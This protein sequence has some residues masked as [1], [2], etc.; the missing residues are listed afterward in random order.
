MKGLL[1]KDFCILK[2][3]MKIVAVLV[4]FYAIWAIVS[5]TPSMMGVM[6]ILL[7]IMLPI[8]SMSYDE[9]GQWYRYA[10][11]LPISRRAL[12]L[13]KYVLGFL[14]A[15]GGLVVSAIGN[16]VVLFLTNWENS[17][18]S[19]LII[20]GFLEIGMIFLSIIIPVL[21]QFGVEKGR[22]LVVVIAV[23]PSL[24]IAMLGSLLKTS[25]VPMPSG[26]VL[27]AIFY[28]SPL[29]T[30]AVFLVSFRISVGI[31]RKKEY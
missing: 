25:G 17:L 5:K 18:E 24:L 16:L 14:V 21:F 23:V 12:V 9:A 15:L 2:K 7:S 19:W 26:D 30:L 27:Q 22:F 1:L 31:C 20:V 8:T 28:S 6:I 13:S 3:Q 4:V 11:S 29:F 10:F